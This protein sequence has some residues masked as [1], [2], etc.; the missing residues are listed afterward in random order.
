M[1]A[2]NT[3]MFPLKHLGKRASVC[4]DLDTGTISFGDS[5]EFKKRQNLSMF[6]YRIPNTLSQ[7]DLDEMIRHSGLP[8]IAKEWSEAWKHGDRE[9]LTTLRTDFVV[10]LHAYTHHEHGH[11]FVH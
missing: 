6:I 1:S 8:E 3:N 4:L 11:E 9:H 10:T 7:H 5:A 2:K